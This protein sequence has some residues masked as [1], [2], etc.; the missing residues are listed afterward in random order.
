MKCDDILLIKG[1]TEDTEGSVPDISCDTRVD[2]L[3]GTKAI[4]QLKNPIN[5]KTG[6]HLLLIAI[7]LTL[8]SFTQDDKG[9]NENGKVKK[10]VEQSAADSVRAA[11]HRYDPR[12]LR[13]GW[14]N[15][16]HFPRLQQ[17]SHCPFYTYV[18][19]GC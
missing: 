8:L 6:F 3:T 4:C 9:K 17:E 15:E 5:M 16:K 14:L 7:A 11:K 10:N 13:S 12:T 2:D 18:K 19:P 1:F